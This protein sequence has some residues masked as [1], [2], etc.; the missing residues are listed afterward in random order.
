MIYVQSYKIIGTNS[1]M[2]CVV[3]PES[4]FKHSSISIVS[5]V[6]Y[7]WMNTRDLPRSI[8]EIP[9]GEHRS[10]MV[11]KYHWGLYKQCADL[12]YK[13]YPMILQHP[14]RVFMG[15]IDLVITDE[16]LQHT[17]IEYYKEVSF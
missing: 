12:I 6:W 15:T 2:F 8:E 17:T 13:A 7:G 10:Y 5:G 1:Q 11:N 9:Y 14:H 3:E 4:D 16:F